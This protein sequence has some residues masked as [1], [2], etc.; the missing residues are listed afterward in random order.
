MARVPLTVRQLKVFDGAAGAGEFAD[1][2]TAADT[3]DFNSFPFTG[4]E[5][6]RARNVGASSR[7]VT[8]ISAPYSK[9]QRVGDITTYSIPAGAQMTL[10]FLPLDGWRQADGSLYINGSHAEVEFSIVRL[11]DVSLPPQI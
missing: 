5:V 1:V 2:F 11:P 7:T 4:K 6:I 9:N 8:V 3:T 10:D